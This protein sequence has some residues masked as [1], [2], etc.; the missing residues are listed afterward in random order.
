MDTLTAMFPDVDADIAQTILDD[1]NGN[2]EAAVLRLLGLTDPESQAREASRTP[3]PRA[4]DDEKLAQRLADEELA[5]H[6]HNAEVHA[7]GPGVLDQPDAPVLDK[8]EQSLHAAGETARRLFGVAA[9][10]AKGLYGRAKAEIDRARAP[11][12]A[13]AE[14]HAAADEPPL[15]R[16]GDVAAPILPS[17]DAESSATPGS[18][19]ASGISAT[20]ASLASPDKKVDPFASLYK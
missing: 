20:P 8:V 7:A 2:V 9:E 5:R 15:V 14:S 11:R 19:S 1:E 16:K 17:R 10:G 6:L 18:S 3:G 12:G 13:A 4:S